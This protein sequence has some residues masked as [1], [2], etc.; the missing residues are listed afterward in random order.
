MRIIQG[1]L[2]PEII[3]FDAKM[4]S[5]RE[6]YRRFPGREIQT[7]GETMPRF[8]ID[9]QGNWCLNPDYIAPA[10]PAEPAQYEQCLVGYELLA[11]K[12]I[13]AEI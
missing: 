3:V 8:K 6:A 4:Q 12:G 11:E 9:G 10:L 1:E 7:F 13:L 5:L 2:G